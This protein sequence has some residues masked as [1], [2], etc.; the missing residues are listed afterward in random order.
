MKRGRPRKGEK[1][2]T[3]AQRKAAW[4][5]KQAKADAIG[6]GPSG[7]P[8][9]RSQG[10]RDAEMRAPAIRAAKPITMDSLLDGLEFAQGR[11]RPAP[12]EMLKGTKS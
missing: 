11:V 8:H 9:G 10:E 6:G 5:D 7:K 2:L 3:P 1:S 12:G 4:K